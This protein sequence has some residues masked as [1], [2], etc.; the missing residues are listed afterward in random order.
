[1]TERSD[2]PSVCTSTLMPDGTYLVRLK[3]EVQERAIRKAN[4]KLAEVI[5]E[6]RAPPTRSDRVRVRT[7]RTDAVLLV[8]L[9]FISLL[10]LGIS[11]TTFVHVV[12]NGGSCSW[13]VLE[14]RGGDDVR[15]PGEG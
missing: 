5:G 15:L 4:D 1:M 8:F 12:L 10:A 9:T 11:V 3:P 13:T 7:G 6:T 2:D 14:T